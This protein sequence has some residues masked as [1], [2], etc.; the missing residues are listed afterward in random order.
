MEK[1]LFDFPIDERWNYE[2]G[3]YITSEPARIGKIIA[4]YELY[5]S[6][7]ALPGQ[8]VECGI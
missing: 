7:A 3:F 8:I 6:I 5:K 1:K 4:Q 2:N